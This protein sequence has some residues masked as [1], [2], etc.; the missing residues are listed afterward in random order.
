M[1]LAVPRKY[2][3]ANL[4]NQI[5]AKIYKANND[6]R[7]ILDTLRY[8]YGKVQPSEK[9]RN[10]TL[11]NAPSVTKDP[12]ET[13]VDRLQECFVFAMITR[14]PYMQEQLMDKA[15]IDSQLTGAF[16]IATLEWIGFTEQ[17]LA[18]IKSTVHQSV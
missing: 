14:P 8:N 1:N 5:G 13:L 12:I 15:L 11:L 10:D 4:V 6:P 18:S 16:E 2:K 3:R 7:R 17:H 9:T